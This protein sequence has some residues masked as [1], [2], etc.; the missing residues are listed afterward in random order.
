MTATEIADPSAELADATEAR[1]PRRRRFST[2]LTVTALTAGV[3]LLSGGI[4][5]V[6]DLWP[7]LRPDPHTE[8]SSSERIVAVDRYVSRLDYL[9]RRYPDPRAFQRAKAHE[10][11]LAAGQSAGLKI[12]GELVYIQVAIHG[13]KG[14]HVTLQRS[15]YDEVSRQRVVPA[16]TESLWTGAA[17]SDQWIAEMW[18]GPVVGPRRKFFVRAEIRDDQGVL[19]AIADS[20]PFSGLSV[21]RITN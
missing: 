16:R 6:F 17:P 13:F 4:G 10:L 19:L 14:G 5:L 20:R 3:A 8:R 18:L 12:K 2:A 1:R 21:D 9:R 11:S 7:G 15:V